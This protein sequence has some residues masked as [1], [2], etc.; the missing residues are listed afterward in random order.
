MVGEAPP[1]V[2]R[3]LW[4]TPL[5]RYS[6]ALEGIFHEQTIIWEDDS[7]CRLLNSI[8]DY[9]AASRDELW[10]DTAYV[11]TGGKDRIPD[12]AGV[13]RQIGVPVK[14][15]F[16]I[17]VLSEKGLI[18]DAVAAFGGEWEEVRPYWSR[19]DSAVRN[20]I[21]PKTIQETKTAI[22]ALLEGTEEDDLPRGQIL[23]IMKQNKSWRIVK[24]FGVSA[25]PDGDSPTRL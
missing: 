25:I 19:V 11:P 17:D 10:R 23:E 9:V 15:V 2:I 7:D 24:Q 20:G 22:V 8:G 21:R 13:L 14:A 12:V 1:E 5:L 16:D 6:N 18:K 4:E 3:K